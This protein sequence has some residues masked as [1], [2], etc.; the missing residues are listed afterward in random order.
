MM[1]IE[2]CILK[3]KSIITQKKEVVSLLFSLHC[4]LDI[5]ALPT[6]GNDLRCVRVR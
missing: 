3:H 5:L 2:K 6:Q 1:I 4:N